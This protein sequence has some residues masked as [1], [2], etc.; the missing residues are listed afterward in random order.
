MSTKKSATTR[1]DLN[2]QE[3]LDVWFVERPG[4][5]G[6][7]DLLAEPPWWVSVIVAALAYF[8]MKSRLPVFLAD[9][10]FC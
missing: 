10:I 3:T 2:G 9:N 1:L 7:F 6:L 8:A 4:K 5:E